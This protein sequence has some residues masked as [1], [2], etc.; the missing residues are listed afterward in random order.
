MTEFNA[1]LA[2]RKKTNS[3]FFTLPSAPGTPMLP[4][5]SARFTTHGMSTSVESATPRPILKLRSKKDRRETRGT[6]CIGLLFVKALK[7]HEHR[8]HA[9]DAGVVRNGGAAQNIERRG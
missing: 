6:F 3:S 9:A 1:S 8:Y 7:G 4:S 5:A 2:P